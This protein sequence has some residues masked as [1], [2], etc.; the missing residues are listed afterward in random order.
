[1]IGLLAYRDKVL[2]EMSQLQHHR[3]TD[4]TATGSPAASLDRVSQSVPEGSSESR[5]TMVAATCS[6]CG[7]KSE[8]IPRDKGFTYWLSD[9]LRAKCPHLMGTGG[10][11][12]P[13]CPRIGEAVYNDFDRWR[14]NAP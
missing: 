8:W 4:F 3:D 9:E 6:T 2:T 11:A 12:Q 10:K 5:E 14:R 7:A 13:Y 1:L